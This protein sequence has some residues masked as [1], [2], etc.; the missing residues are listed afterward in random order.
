MKKALFLLSL[1]SG[2]A[3]FRPTASI[4]DPLLNFYT[5]TPPAH[6]QAALRLTERAREEVHARKYDIATEHLQK[7]LTIDPQCPFAYYFLALSSHHTGDYKKSNG[8]LEKAKQ[9][10][11]FSPFWKAQSY[12]LSGLNFEK[13]GNKKIA[14]A[15]FKKAKEIDPNL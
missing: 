1:L 9:L 2:C 11:S 6:T 8:F 7:A 10:F 4:D 13:L 14:Q 15:Q 12:H 3:L 5:D